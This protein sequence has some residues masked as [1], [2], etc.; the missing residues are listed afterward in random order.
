[1]FNAAGID[2]STSGYGIS[3]SGKCVFG[4]KD[5]FRWMVN[6]GSG[7]GRYMGLNI[8]NGAVLD[9]DGNLHAIDSTSAFGS[10]RHLWNDKWRSNLTYGWV[11]IDNDTDLTGMG[12]TKTAH[13]YHLNLIY[14]PQPKLDFGAEIL[15]ATREVE[16]GADGDMTR[17]QFSAKYAY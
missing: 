8:A 11:N 4:N 16:S 13:S 14:S 6:T 5:D 2:D 12:V 3:L 9:A 7:M 10:Y 15:W 1:M 17:L